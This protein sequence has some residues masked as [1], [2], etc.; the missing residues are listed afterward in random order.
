MSRP[1]VVWL[2]RLLLDVAVA[3]EDHPGAATRHPG[4]ETRRGPIGYPGA[5]FP[6][7][8]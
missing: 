5:P 1:A 6:A 8:T 2:R 7:G 3:V 4:A